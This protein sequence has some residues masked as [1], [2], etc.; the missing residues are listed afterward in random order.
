MKRNGVSINEMALKC[1]VHRA[2][3][4][5]WI[6][7]GRLRTVR[8]GPRKQIIDPDEADRFIRDNRI[9]ATVT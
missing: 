5:S 4:H 8:I 6:K 7:N 3:V 2:T 1:D 9:I